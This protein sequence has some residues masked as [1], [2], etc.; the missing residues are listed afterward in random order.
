MG[1]NPAFADRHSG[2]GAPPSAVIRPFSFPRVHV[3]RPSIMVSRFHL[4]DSDMFVSSYRPSDWASMPVVGRRAGPIALL[5]PRLSWSSLML[6]DSGP[7][8]TIVGT[9]T[10]QMLGA[11]CTHF[12]PPTCRCC[13]FWVAPKDP[14][15][16]A[17]LLLLL[18]ENNYVVGYCTM[19]VRCG[20][21]RHVSH[22]FKC[23][24]STTI[25]SLTS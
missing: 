23:L 5:P 7:L 11:M 15:Y 12:N 8:H 14:R 20:G 21:S 9:F 13:V 22:N 6:V 16:L 3:T 4:L 1:F 10:L 17:W 18:R 25:V 19:R 2:V 24:R